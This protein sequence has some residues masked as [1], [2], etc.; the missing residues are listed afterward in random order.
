MIS[1]MYFLQQAEQCS[2]GCKMLRAL[3]LWDAAASCWSFCVQ[4]EGSSSMSNGET[5]EFAAHRP[6][7]HVWSLDN[8]SAA[9]SCSAL[10]SDK[11]KCVLACLVATN[12]PNHTL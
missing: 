11:P 6:V 8:P 4:A 9:Q 3:L 12:C 5:W 2:S 10:E 7:H 1:L